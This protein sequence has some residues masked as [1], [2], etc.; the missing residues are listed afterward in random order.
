MLLHAVM[1][2]AQLS[3]PDSTYEGGGSGGG[4]E[5]YVP[6]KAVNE[7]GVQFDVF[8]GASPALTIGGDWRSMCMSTFHTRCC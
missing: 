1:A 4:V 6:G 3:A 8:D 2:I 5:W 7:K